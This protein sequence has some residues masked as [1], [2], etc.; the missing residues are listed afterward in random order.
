[1]HYFKSV[2]TAA[3]IIG[4]A[5]AVALPVDTE[6]SPDM[7]LVNHVVGDANIPSPE[8]TTPDSVRI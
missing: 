6:G 3:G 4:L 7:V 8:F 5:H 1:M 2:V